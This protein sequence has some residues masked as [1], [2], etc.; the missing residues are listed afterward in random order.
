M[1]YISGYKGDLPVSDEWRKSINKQLAHVTFERDVAPR[2]ITRDVQLALY[3][4][5]KKA[6]RTFRKDLPE[7]YAREFRE[8]VLE[9]KALPNG[10]PSEFSAYDLD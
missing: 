1:H 10:Q 8:R 6:W 5:L 4:E 9:R 7:S 3:D 2:E